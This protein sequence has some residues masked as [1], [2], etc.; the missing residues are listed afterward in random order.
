MNITYVPLTIGWIVCTC[1]EYNTDE[2]CMSCREKGMMTCELYGW[3]HLL[4]ASHFMYMAVY[5]HLRLMHLSISPSP[6]RAR[7]H[8][9]SLS[10]FRKLQQM[11][12]GLLLQHSIWNH[13]CTE[14]D[15][16]RSGG[17]SLLLY[18][19]CSN[20]GC[21]WRLAEPVSACNSILVW[22]FRPISDWDLC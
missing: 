11:L 18:I 20:G 9:L 22:T 4:A 13:L 8:T 15:C 1:T 10:T 6:M 14:C 5:L 3:Q 7:T 17:L 12:Q 16:S 19:R 21:Q 2:L